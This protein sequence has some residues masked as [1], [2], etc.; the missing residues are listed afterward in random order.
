M[1]FL[2]LISE[3]IECS[4]IN[5]TEDI[6]CYL[7]ENMPIK[8]M[9]LVKREA[10]FLDVQDAWREVPDNLVEVIASE[11]KSPAPSRHFLTIPIDNEGNLFY[12]LFLV[13]TTEDSE[14]NR[15]KTDIAMIG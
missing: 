6:T 9:A 3:A 10:N 2:D 14:I 11:T 7:L 5:I 13:E 15:V 1:K 8:G 4:V 12:A